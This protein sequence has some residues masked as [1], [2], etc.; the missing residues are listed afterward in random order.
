MR[1]PRRR[2]V[3]ESL[4]A[5]GRRLLGSRIRSGPAAGLRFR[6]GDTIGYVLGL[7]E[8]GLQQALSR[9][10]QSGD[11][12]YDIG[13]HAGFVSVLGCR[14]VGPAGHVHCFEPVPENV[15][16]LR[17]N[18]DA[19]DFRNA[20]IHAIALSDEEGEVRMDLGERGITAHLASSGE[21]TT[22][23]TRCDSLALAPPSMVKIDVEGA[24]SRVL[25][26]MR[27]TLAAQRPVIVVEVHE[28]QDAPVRRILE[29]LRYDI[30]ELD[31]TGGMPHLLALPRKEQ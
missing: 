1:G 9:H 21:F 11:V 3:Y 10:L 22:R 14:L 13:A 27:Q 2:R 28:G 24:E 5:V 31:D 23:A 17:S 4:N 25:E 20:T 12:L 19:N 26:G 8:P 18:L 30:S 29:E 6:G 16:T 15:S 7:S